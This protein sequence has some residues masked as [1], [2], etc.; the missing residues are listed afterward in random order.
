VDRDATA[1]DLAR[2]RAIDPVERRGVPADVAPVVAFRASDGARFVTG[3]TV[4]VDGGRGAVPV[5]GQYARNR[6]AGLG[7]GG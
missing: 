3:A 4:P 1:E 2:E 5:D 7:D 6:R